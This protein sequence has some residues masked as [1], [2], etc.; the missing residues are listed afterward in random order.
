MSAVENKRLLQSFVK[1]VLDGQNPDA[2]DRYL[3][4]NFFHHDRPPGLG[5]GQETGL[6]GTKQFLAT[7][8]F[9]TFSNFRTRFEDVIA[10]DDLVAGR[11]VQTVTHSGPSFGRPATGKQITIPG[12]SI[13][14]IRDNKIIEEWEARDAVTLLQELGVISSLGILEWDARDAIDTSP[15]P[16]RP[17]VDRI[18]D[19]KANK[20]MVDRFFFDA[21]NA[22]RPEVLK[23]LFAPNF[24]N[25]NP[26]KGQMAGIDGVRQFISRFHTAF[27]DISLSADLT[28][29]E[30]D[31]VVTRW[32]VRGTHKDTFMDIPATNRF[33]TTTGINIFSVRGGQISEGWGQWER[34]AM[35]EQL[36][37]IRQ[38]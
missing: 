6:A 22:K 33:I 9:P 25:R 32:T 8:V 4:D 31:K 20:Q 2:L 15:R 29:A 36:G 10:E 14:R 27:P 34:A 23:E 5:P 21:W 37:V 18:G 7:Q 11:W 28:L 26:L 30:G 35:L 19:V 17:A 12:I 24:V 16:S 13:V 1:E 3:A 38:P